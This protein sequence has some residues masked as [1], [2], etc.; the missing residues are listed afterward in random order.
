MSNT[1]K[2]LLQKAALLKDCSY[3][4]RTERVEELLIELLRAGTDIN[5]LEEAEI[6]RTIAQISLYPVKSLI[7]M[8]NILEPEH[9]VRNRPEK[10][11]TR[12]QQRIERAFNYFHRHNTY[13]IMLFDQIEDHVKA[14]MFRAEGF[15]DVKGMFGV[16]ETYSK[17]D[18]FRICQ[19]F[20]GRLNYLEQTKHKQMAYRNKKHRPYI[21]DP[22]YVGVNL[23]RVKKELDKVLPGWVLY[24]GKE[25]EAINLN[26][27][28]TLRNH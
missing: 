9:G 22:E 24:G 16:P 6:L 14:I 11:L 7:K 23:K 4:N 26:Q 21:I 8:I 20:Y 12:N 1:H 27:Y 28:D 15:K 2:L 13:P 3:I 19:R 5:P 17:K 10:I 18:L 25:N